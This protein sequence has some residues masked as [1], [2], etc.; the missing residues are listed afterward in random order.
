MDIREEAE[1]RVSSREY[2][3]AQAELQRHSL[4]SSRRLPSARERS[5]TRDSKEISRS[6]PVSLSL[7]LAEAATLADIDYKL[8]GSRARANSHDFIRPRWVPDAE[9]MAC[10]S[11]ECRME[12]DWYNR[13]H[14]CRHCGQIFCNACTSHRLLL[15]KEFACRDPQRVC[16][17]CQKILKPLQS[18]LTNDVANHQRINS[19]EPIVAN[20]GAKSLRRYFNM[21]YSS[22]LGSEIRKA[23]YSVYNLFTL[24]YIK[25]KSIPLS[26]LQGAKGLAFLTVVQGGFVFGGRFGSG[27]VVSKLPSGGWS[28]P[29]AIGTCGLSWGALVGVELTDYVVVLTDQEAVEAFSGVGQLSLGAEIAVAVGP[30][31]R[32]GSVEFHVGDGGLAPVYSYSHSRGAYAG[33]SLDGCLLFARSAVNFHFYGR[34]VSPSEILRGAVPPPRAAQPL[35]DAL[36]QAFVVAPPAQHVS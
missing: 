22:T 16:D 30:V 27:L 9:V 26:L 13:R 23:A 18:T 33:A 14:H 7:T 11:P 35:Y 29:S 24:Q 2:S 5:G 15:P 1:K 21:P 25:D 19:I 10:S 12:F 8:N 32:T 20:G 34:E 28:A 17:S 36:A 31:G 3:L 4:R 6:R